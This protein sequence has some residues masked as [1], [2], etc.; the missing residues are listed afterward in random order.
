[1]TTA[2]TASTSDT[3]PS[4]LRKRKAHTKSRRGCSS[5]KTRRV[6]CDE[7]KPTCEQCTKFGVSCVYG[8]KAAGLKFTGESSFDLNDP[9]PFCPDLSTTTTTVKVNDIA[10]LLNCQRPSL[11]STIVAHCNVLPSP[12]DSDEEK[13]CYNSPLSLAALEVL[14][15]FNQRTVLSVGTTQA[16]AVYQKEVFRLAC[17]VRSSKHLIIGNGKSN[18]V[19]YPFLKNIVITLTLLHDRHLAGT[20]SISRAILS[21]WYH[22]TAKFK[23]A[24]MQPLKNEIRDALW[25]SAALLGVI[26][27]AS[28]DVRS[29]QEAWPLKPSDPS[30]LD[31]LKMSEGK[32]AIFALTDPLRSDS[33]FRKMSVNHGSLFRPMVEP[34]DYHKPH[35]ID[36][37]RDFIDM[38]DLGPT[39]TRYDN[40][41]YR[42]AMMLA[43][44]LHIKCDGNNILEFFGFMMHMGPKLRNMLDEKDAKA[45][46]L[47]VYWYAKL[48]R[49]Q[50]W[51]HRRGLM[52]G[53]AICM[54][55]DKYH[56][57]D[58]KL[59]RMLEWPK[60]E[61]GLEVSLP[62]RNSTSHWPSDAAAVLCVM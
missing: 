51:L 3:V 42:P 21:H 25:A 18:S 39:S 8:G 2:P 32:K 22:G 26:Q 60:A 16:A 35:A 11:F 30:D 15:R 12:L 36:L 52:E 7:N 45:L 50:W 23:E 17:S 29:V 55:L 5:C 58:V 56:G 46:L 54:Y 43:R 48:Y 9:I 53:Q 61:L 59:Q 28:I 1:M 19:Q 40:P 34:Q 27:F 4:A 14:G 62:G 44:L 24:L 31:W 20:P 6:K 41:Y 57:H 38:F 37:T 49:G 47:V 10:P 13:L 33:A